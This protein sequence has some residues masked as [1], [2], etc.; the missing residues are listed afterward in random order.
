MSTKAVLMTLS[1]ILPTLVHELH[2]SIEDEDP[3]LT[4]AEDD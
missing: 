4:E 3:G 2:H 1:K